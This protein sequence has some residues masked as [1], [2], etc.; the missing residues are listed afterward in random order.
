MRD[1]TLLLS[2]EVIC[3]K[4]CSAILCGPANDSNGT[5]QRTIHHQPLTCNGRRD[6][7]AIFAET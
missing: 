5:I 7:V 3:T 6:Y 4:V 2:I 1:V